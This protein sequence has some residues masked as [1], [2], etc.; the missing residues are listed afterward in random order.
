MSDALRP[1]TPA[2]P[3]S[4][5]IFCGRASLCFVDIDRI[6]R[7]QLCP[8]ATPRRRLHRPRQSRLTAAERVTHP[9]ASRTK[10]APFRAHQPLSQPREIHPST[11]LSDRVGNACTGEADNIA[12]P[13][14]A[15]A[16]G[17]TICFA[18]AL[19]ST[20]PQNGAILYNMRVWN[21][22]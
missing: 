9:L 2:A 3:P 6:I 17:P 21:N 14:Q 8:P 12:T 20:S 4:C 22:T 10:I 5:Q 19:A 13:L 7:R 16:D 1:T 15:P 18:R 11:V